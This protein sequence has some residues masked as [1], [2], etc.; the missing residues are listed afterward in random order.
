MSD[1]IIKDAAGTVRELFYHALYGVDKVS[2][3][4]LE[5]LRS[6]DYAKF[7]LEETARLHEDFAAAYKRAEREMEKY[8]LL[9]ERAEREERDF[10]ERHRQI[11]ASRNELEIAVL[12]ES[13]AL[14]EAFKED[15]RKSNRRAKQAEKKA[16]ASVLSKASGKDLIELRDLL[17]ESAPR[18]RYTKVIES[19]ILLRMEQGKSK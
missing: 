2:D 16:A 19:E 6:D 17:K 12:E 13:N 5:F 10:R 11:E 3:E 1:P 8:K 9:K 15:A 4:R 18:A 14:I 7:M